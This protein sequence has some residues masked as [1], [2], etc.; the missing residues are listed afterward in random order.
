MQYR[1]KITI[2]V[3]RVTNSAIVSK[4]ILVW[5][6]GRPENNGYT[7][8]HK[9][10]LLKQANLEGFSVNHLPET[11]IFMMSQMKI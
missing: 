5:L 3:W 11:K 8:N 6:C 1:I 10:Q 2:A 4:T 9:I 7:N